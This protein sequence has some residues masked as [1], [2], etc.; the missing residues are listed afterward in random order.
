MGRYRKQ[1]PPVKKGNPP[2]NIVNSGNFSGCNLGPQGE[3]T[4]GTPVQTLNS[5]GAPPPQPRSYGQDESVS[6]K[7][8]EIPRTPSPRHRSRTEDSIN[9]NDN[10]KNDNGQTVSAP[11][12][13]DVNTEAY[14]SDD[15]K[16]LQDLREHNWIELMTDQ[17]SH[18]VYA[19]QIHLPADT[20][21]EKKLLEKAR[22]LCEQEVPFFYGTS[23]VID[24]SDLKTLSCFTEQQQAELRKLI[25]SL[26]P[27]DQDDKLELLFDALNEVGNIRH[28]QAFIQSPRADRRTRELVALLTVLDDLE[29]VQDR[30]GMISELGEKKYRDLDSISQSAIT[31][32]CYKWDTLEAA[33]GLCGQSDLPE[34]HYVMNFWNE[35]IDSMFLSRNQMMIRQVLL[36]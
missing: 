14:D 11:L 29:N 8:S 27:Q 2:P 5:E 15:E 7:H 20:T 1:G 34:G 9:S 23:F 28:L 19:E 31:Y 21:A 26:K 16:F 36:T 17:F 6:L 33:D 35:V 30:N 24:F 32:V 25:P 10:P 12:E 3:L 22:E 4:Q 13:I 18:M